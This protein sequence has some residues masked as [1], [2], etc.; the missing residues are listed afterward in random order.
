M[1]AIQIAQTGGPESIHLVDLDRPVPAP[2]QVLVEIHAI[3]VNFIDIYYRE[4]V[5]PATLPITLGQ[6]AAGVIVEVGKNVE[7]F[8]VGERVAWCTYLGAYAE[9]AV[10]PESHLVSIPARLTFEQAA[11]SLLQGMTAQY[12]SSST[13][14]LKAGDTALIHAG[15]GGVG[16]L[17]TQMAVQAGAHVISTVS[18]EEKADIVRSTG[19]HDV[20]L[21]TKEDFESAVKRITGGRGVD[22][23]YD[24]VGRETFDRSLKCLRA[25]GMMVLFGASSG[26]VPPVDPIQLSRGGS[27]FLTRPS[28]AHYTQSREEL[29]ARSSDVFGRLELGTLELH[30]HQMFPLSEAAQ[31]QEALQ[32]RATTGKLLL[33]P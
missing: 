25:R 19:A 20:I 1:K 31:A 17:L 6:E 12:L 28:L 4:G 13:F 26:A 33:V 21:Y 29:D 22:V 2:N 30:I 15:A 10:V 9:Y 18:T 27:L 23:V 8:R 3:G 16:Y 32:S 7:H 24:S 14:A 11:A 5:Y